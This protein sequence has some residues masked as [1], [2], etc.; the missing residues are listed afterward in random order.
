LE[1][2]LALED[3]AGATLFLFSFL[4][5]LREGLSVTVPA[6]DIVLLWKV[7]DSVGELSGDFRDILMETG[8]KRGE[9][10]AGDGGPSSLFLNRN[11]FRKLVFCSFEGIGDRSGTRCSFD[12][13]V[14]IG[15]R[16][17]RILLPSV[18]MGGG[19]LVFPRSFFSVS[20]VDMS[21]FN[22]RWILG[23]V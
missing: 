11:I 20:V 4:D 6:R 21:W 7:S 16:G 5:L 22:D 10:G 1:S 14:I 15:G 19:S 12:S 3:F 18:L 9:L 17:R 2:D 13:S 8:E 23:K